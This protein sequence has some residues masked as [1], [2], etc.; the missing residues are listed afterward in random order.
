MLKITIAEQ[1]AIQ[2]WTSPLK[3]YRYIKSILKGEN[4][5]SLQTIYEIRANDLVNIFDKYQDNSNDALLYRGDIIES[6][7]EYEEYFSKNVDNII[8]L[9][10]TILSFTLSKDIAEFS[11]KHSDKMIN[12]DTPSILFILENRKSTFLDISEYSHFPNEKEVICNQGIKFIITN[13]VREP[14]NHL[15]FYIDET[16]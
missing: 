12:K 10:D 3:E 13:I 1:K 16:D 11:Y 14:N 4:I 7:T 9:E 15:I 8:I 2:S 6:Q 5:G